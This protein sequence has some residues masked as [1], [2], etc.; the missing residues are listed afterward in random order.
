MPSFVEEE[1]AMG[2]EN[3][4]FEEGSM[5][6]LGK[7]LSVANCL[8]RDV[9]KGR[10]SKHRTLGLHWEN[11]LEELKNVF[12]DLVFIS[13]ARIIKVTRASETHQIPEIQK[14]RDLGLKM[15]HLARKCDRSK[16]LT[17]FEVNVVD[18]N[19]GGLSL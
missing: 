12:V 8:V 19:L 13:F 15:L 9:R 14:R 11:R 2:Q 6:C 16:L 10:S 4:T 1:P 17:N 5:S 7:L 3:L 18:G